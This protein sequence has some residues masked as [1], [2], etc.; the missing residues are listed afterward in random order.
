MF[1]NMDVN[2]QKYLTLKLK[3]LMKPSHKCLSK[4]L[5]RYAITFGISE[6]DHSF[7]WLCQLNCD[8]STV[9]DC[10]IS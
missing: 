3:R 10:L 7:Y 8:I 9:L 6:Y 4:R 1:S 2:L 5:Q